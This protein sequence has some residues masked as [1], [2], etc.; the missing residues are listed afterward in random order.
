MPIYRSDQGTLSVTVAGITI[1]NQSWDTAEGGDITVE[2]QEYNPG[3]MAPAVAIGGKRSRSAMT[4]KRAWDDTLIGAYKALDNAAGKTP[5][6]IGYQVL[7][8]DHRTPVGNPIT[9]TGILGNVTRPGYDSMTSTVAMLQ[10]VVSLNE[11]IS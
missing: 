2:S 5:V 6:T 10:I 9:Y 7:A 8:A 1:D 11:T 4:V 3:A